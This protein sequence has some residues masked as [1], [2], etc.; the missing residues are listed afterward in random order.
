MVALDDDSLAQMNFVE[1]LCGGFI[2]G[3]MGIMILIQAIYIC[4]IKH[5][6]SRLL[7]LF[8]YFSAVQMFWCS[9]PPRAKMIYWPQEN[10]YFVELLLFY[11]KIFLS[12]D[13]DAF[14][15]FLSCYMF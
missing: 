7:F 3:I 14:V 9:L 5:T 13:K 1:Q 2:M 8:F 6:L 11:E 4:T 12:Q 10:V 15:H